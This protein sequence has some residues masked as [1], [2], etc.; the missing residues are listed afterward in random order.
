[1][2]RVKSY[3]YILFDLDDTL[4]DFKASEAKALEDTLVKFG[5]TPSKEIIKRYSEINVSYWRK[6]DI[7]LI[8]KDVLCKRRFADFGR[9]LGMDESVFPSASV[10]RFYLDQLGSYGILFEGAVELCKALRNRG[11]KIMIITNGTAHVQHSRLQAT[12]FTDCIDGLYISEEIGYR[13]PTVEYFSHVLN[14]I[15]DLC[16]EHYLIVGDSLTSDIAGGVF[17]GID[18]CWFNP[19]SAINDKSFSPTYNVKN[20][21]EILALLQ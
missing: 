11:Y 13:K 8:E 6:F 21:S 9:E 7:G 19:N 17:N 20:Y 3:K 12:G 16:K 5:I 1:M 4:F 10:N 2:D 18:T 14:N 15:G